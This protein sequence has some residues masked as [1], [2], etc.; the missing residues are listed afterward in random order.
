VVGNHPC[1][2]AV[3]CAL[4]NNHLSAWNKGQIYLIYDDPEAVVLWG[5]ELH[6]KQSTCHHQNQYFPRKKGI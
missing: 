1:V 6:R 2:S 4:R 5:L 3:A